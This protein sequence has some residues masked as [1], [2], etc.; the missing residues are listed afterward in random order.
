[1]LSSVASRTGSFKPNRNPGDPAMRLASLSLFAVLALLASTASAIDFEGPTDTPPG[2]G[3]SS[4]GGDPARAGGLTLTYT[5]F[6]LT[7]TSALYFG[8][9]NDR[10]VNGYSMDGGTITGSEVL[11]YASRTVDTITYTGL[12]TLVTDA[13]SGSWPTATRVTY[14]ITGAGEWVEDEDTQALNGEN[15]DVQALWL[16]ESTDFTVNVLVEAI[17]P[18]FDPN[19]G[20]FE[21]GN[22]LFDRL[23]TLGETALSLDW[24]FY[25]VPEP[26]PT[27]LGAASLLTL[28][29]VRARRRRAGGWCHGEERLQQDRKR[30]R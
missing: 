15:G 16:V 9:R 21:P 12:T 1:M 26:G 22:D 10:D 30:V 29:S 25:F 28:V 27:V 13:P 6:D 20:N 23:G 24:G 3:D 7:Q 5:D 17:V 19:G 11:R 18:S 8:V 4:F 14:T 2:G